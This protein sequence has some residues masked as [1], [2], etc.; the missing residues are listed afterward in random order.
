MEIHV[1]TALVLAYQALP[2]DHKVRLRMIQLV[3]G[4]EEHVI[5]TTGQIVPFPGE[6]LYR[7]EIF[8]RGS[9]STNDVFTGGVRHIYTE[10]FRCPPV[11]KEERKARML[12]AY[13][14]ANNHGTL[15]LWAEATPVEFTGEPEGE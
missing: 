13:R 11:E 7:F 5:E 10:L 9:R 15:R 8:C 1:V 4:L 12:H 3:P 2:V 6:Q 14:R